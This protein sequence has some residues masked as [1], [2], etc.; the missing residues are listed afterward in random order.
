M[1]HLS[2]LLSNSAPVPCSALCSPSLVREASPAR[3]GY[4][5]SRVSGRKKIAPAGDISGYIR[6]VPGPTY[7]GSAL[8]YMPPLA[9]KGEACSVT[10]QA[11]A[12][13][14]PSDPR[15]LKLSSNTSHSGVGYHAP[16]A[17]TTLNPCVFLC[18]SYFPTNEQTL[19][20]LLILGFKAGALRHPGDFLS[21]TM[22]LR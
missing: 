7:R 10:T 12:H 19:R 16:V 4:T 22:N 20:P 6:Y 2:S 8:L 17:R 13:S 3:R 9:I 18:S 11:Q 1:V 21:D 14:D 5:R 15:Q